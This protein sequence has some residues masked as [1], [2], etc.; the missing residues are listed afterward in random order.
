MNTMN[1]GRQETDFA[2]NSRKT[3][4][5]DRKLPDT[6]SSPSLK[7]IDWGPGE[8]V[9]ARLWGKWED[10]TPT[11]ME[12]DWLFFLYSCFEIQT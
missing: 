6:V 5:S 9:C 1:L 12:K 7:I 10:S 11:D 8:A 4:G 3:P 2:T